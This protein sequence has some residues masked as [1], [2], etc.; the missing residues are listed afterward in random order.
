MSSSNKPAPFRGL[1]GFVAGMLATLPMSVFML[2]MNRLVPPAK[3]DTLP[4][5]EITRKAIQ[6]TVHA[7][8]PE[9]VL[10]GLTLFNHFGYGAAVGSLYP[11]FRDFLP[12]RQPVATGVL[13]GLLVWM[14]SYLG[15]MPGVRL[16][17]SAKDE[18]ARMNWIMILAHIIWGGFAGVLTERLSPKRVMPGV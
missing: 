8:P 2:G 5:K 6:K 15:L 1:S 10:N 9:P 13:F 3:G 12:G 18:P 7:T 4:P 11:A 17:P 14:V 16:Y